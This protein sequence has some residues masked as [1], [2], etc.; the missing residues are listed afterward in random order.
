LEREE[1]VANLSFAEYALE[2]LCVAGKVGNK[3]EWKWEH[4]WKH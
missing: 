4:E 2:C 3:W 1:G